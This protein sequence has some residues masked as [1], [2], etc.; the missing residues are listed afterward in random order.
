MNM[1]NM[2]LP[3]PTP[4]PVVKKKRRS[5]KTISV[6]LSPEAERQE[7]ELRAKI[8]QSLYTQQESRK[9][10]EVVDETFGAVSHGN[11][12]TTHYVNHRDGEAA[13]TEQMMMMLSGEMGIQTNNRGKNIGE[14][15]MQQNQA[16]DLFNQMTTISS[17]EDVQTNR[18]MNIG[19]LEMQQE[20]QQVQANDLFNRMN[21]ISSKEANEIYDIG[22]QMQQMKRQFELQSYELEQRLKEEKEM[23]TQ[24]MINQVEL[25]NYELEKTLKQEKEMQ[26]QQF[27]QQQRVALFQSQFNVL[28]ETSAIGDINTF[29]QHAAGT[30]QARDYRNQQQQQSSPRQ[31]AKFLRQQQH[32]QQLLTLHPYL[33]NG[34]LP[35]SVSQRGF[36]ATNSNNV[37]HSDGPNTVEDGVARQAMDY[38]GQHLPILHPCQQCDTSLSMQQVQQTEVPVMHKSAGDSTIRTFSSS[39]TE[40]WMKGSMGSDYAFNSVGEDVGSGIFDNSMNLSAM[41]SERELKSYD[42]EDISERPSQ[43]EDEVL[44]TITPTIDLI[45]SGRRKRSNTTSKFTAMTE[46]SQWTKEVR[47]FE[48]VVQSEDKHKSEDGSRSDTRLC[49]TLL[50]SETAQSIRQTNKTEMNTL[51][52]P[53]QEN[54]MSESDSNKEFENSALSNNFDGNLSMDSKM[55]E[56]LLKKSGQ[57]QDMCI[58]NFSF[59]DST[60]G[61]AESSSSS[62]GIQKVGSLKSSSRSNKAS[63]S[64]TRSSIMS[65]ITQWSEDNPFEASEN[66]KGSN[67]EKYDISCS[68]L[69]LL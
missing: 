8:Q 68:G 6:P 61:E 13:A 44:K 9:K 67:E 54:D 39:I 55:L 62:N 10:I 66:D 24:Q 60:G 27:Q 50:S 59:F 19:G 2:F 43:S 69:S 20:Y 34:Q 37:W 41:F 57:S 52:L 18:G 65:E 58:S 25:Q 1:N 11:N 23:K 49:T 21:T 16:N 63:K 40:S 3:T 46:I 30:D 47:P 22:Q 15:E 32:R 48:A 36:M 45:N 33:Y 17:D 14:L 5:R 53:I 35:F 12:S 56:D 31:L 42:D 28:S 4:T 26:V 51:L 38:V 64:T 29:F 7:R